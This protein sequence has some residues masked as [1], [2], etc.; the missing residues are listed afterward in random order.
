M[1][2]IASSPARRLTKSAMYW[3]KSAPVAVEVFR[4][5]TGTDS[6]NASPVEIQIFIPCSF[7]PLGGHMHHP[8]ARGFMRNEAFMS[9]EKAMLL[10]KA[11]KDLTKVMRVQNVINAADARCRNSNVA[12]TD[13]ASRKIIERLEAEMDGSDGN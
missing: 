4:K 7:L 6:W 13:R 10:I 9:D 5:D 2:S 3:T 1:R 8:A 12:D 11:I